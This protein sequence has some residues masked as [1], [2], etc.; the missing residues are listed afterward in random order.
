M[1]LAAYCLL[2]FH[3]CAEPSR[4]TGKVIDF[5]VTERIEADGLSAAVEVVRDRYGVPHIYGASEGD[6]AFVQGWIHSRDR[7]FQM[8]VQRAAALG[9]TAVLIGASR[10]PDDILSQ[11]FKFKDVALKLWASGT[12]EDE[13]AFLQRYADGVNASLRAMQPQDL[14]LEFLG[15]GIND[16]DTIYSQLLRIND[17]QDGWSPIDTIAFARLM[18]HQ[19]SFD[20]E[21]SEGERF[22]AI[23]KY[24]APELVKRGLATSGTAAQL[25]ALSWLKDLYP[26]V[27]NTAAII[28]Q[29]GTYGRRE[30][31]PGRWRASRS[32]QTRTAATEGTRALGRYVEDLRS[33]TGL[34]PASNNWVVRGTISESGHPMLAN[35]PHLSLQNPPVFHEVHI[36]TKEKGGDLNAAG[37]MFPMAP[38]VVIGF[39]ERLAWGDTVVGYDVTD[40]YVEPVVSGDGPPEKWMI[41][42][43]GREDVALK[44]VIGG[45]LYNSPG[46][47]CSLPAQVQQRLDEMLVTVTSN[48]PFLGRCKLDFRTY[49]VAGHGPVVHVSRDDSGKPT[50]L[51]TVKWTGMEPSAELRAFH[52]YLTSQTIQDFEAAVSEF[53]VGAQ[54]QVVMDADNNIGWYPNAWVPRRDPL[55]CKDPSGLSVPFYLPQPGTGVCEW[56]GMIDENDLPRLKNPERGY[57]ATANHQPTASK[58]YYH[59][60]FY[61]IGYR[62]ARITQLL[63]EK[64]NAGKIGVADMKRIQADTHLLLCDDFLPVLKSAIAGR[65]AEAGAS[66]ESAGSLLNDYDCSSPS[67]YTYDRLRGADSLDVSA[68]PKERA[69]SAAASIFHSWFSNFVHLTFDDQLGGQNLA[70]QQYARAIYTITFRK[71]CADGALSSGEP[72]QSSGTAATGTSPFWDDWSTSDTIESRDDIA[73]RAFADAL[74]GL[75]VKFG[76]PDPLQWLWGRL[77]TLTVRHFAS[78]T[79]NSPSPSEKRFQELGLSGFPRPGGAFVVDASDPGFGVMNAA[80]QADYAY[81]SGPSY[82]LVVEMTPSGPEAHTAL[83]GGN[84]AHLRSAFYD[85]QLREFWWANQ[86]KEFPFTRDEVERAARE[87]FLFAPK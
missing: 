52:R 67:G 75:T 10:I 22:E 41:K 32:R 12:T 63:E 19:L 30:S 28:D 53:K 58:S 72:C 48:N 77:H 5:P 13:R 50:S 57:I 44:A 78:D 55:T 65:A 37:V 31:A 35:D 40:F 80:T 74:A 33:L 9:E 54:N 81:R 79:F 8:V 84:V 24:L 69:R 42:S 39:N 60:S 25:T 3:A 71:N 46:G 43:Q 85:N 87:L 76:T 83:P 29:P 14:P 59:G 18:T 16:P 17:S 68:D 4:G 45:S 73:R 26:T 62:G 1:L 86:Y 49:E 66:G 21:G 38:G 7:L 56:Q 70:G 15:Q 6:V 11:M 36:N 20:D 51:I 82:R 23:L 61:D 34:V 47:T 2:G 64:K 27:G